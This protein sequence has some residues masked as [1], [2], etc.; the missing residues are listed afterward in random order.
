MP[1][2]HQEGVFGDILLF[3]LLLMLGVERLQVF[4]RG[5]ELFRFGAEE[6]QSLIVIR[7]ELLIICKFHAGTEFFQKHLFQRHTVAFGVFGKR[8]LQFVQKLLALFPDGQSCLPGFGSHGLNLLPAAQGALQEVLLPGHVPFHGFLGVQALGEIQAE[9]GGVAAVLGLEHI[10]LPPVADLQNGVGQ[11]P[12]AH[13]CHH[14]V[15]CGLYGVILSGVGALAGSVVRVAVFGNRRRL[16]FFRLGGLAGF[17]SGA[18]GGKGLLRG[19]ALGSR[20]NQGDQC[21]HQNHHGGNGQGQLTRGDLGLLGLGRLFGGSLLRGFRGGNFRRSSFLR[22]FLRGGILSRGSFRSGL[23]CGLLGYYFGFFLLGGVVLG[24]PALG[25]EQVLVGHL[26][27]AI[28]A[29][30][31]V[32]S[33]FLRKNKRK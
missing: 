6:F 14:G 3:V 5:L 29:S 32:G 15:P 20:H 13:R 11:F 30:F 23:F 7:Q 16:R 10:N 22:D 18:V 26:C 28:F 19:G 33:S 21:C 4:L 2:V 24:L 27:A 17:Q 12:I 1:H 25:A 31:H 8:I 9:V